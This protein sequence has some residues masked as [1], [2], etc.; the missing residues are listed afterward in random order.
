MKKYLLL[1]FSVVFSTALYAQSDVVIK[2]SKKTTLEA[3][4]KQVID[5][6]KKKFPNAQAVQYYKTSPSAAENGWDVSHQD[7]LGSGSI[8]RYTLSF[9]RSDFQYYALFAADG[10]LLK[11]KYQENG[12]TLPE[13]AKA[14]LKKH[15]GDDYK[16]YTLISKTYFKTV[17]YGTHKNYYEVVAVS[18]TDPSKK[19]TV[20]LDEA[21]NIVKVK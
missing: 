4:P 3:T 14:S 6:L 7:N 9:K 12:A 16:N 15:A 13:A 8:D 17:D 21:G 2:A 11:S 18:K 19:K 1:V 20:T 10:T 5:S